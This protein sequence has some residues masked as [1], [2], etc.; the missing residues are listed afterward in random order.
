MWLN[1][2]EINHLV[3]DYNGIFNHVVIKNINQ[4]FL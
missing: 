3:C 1:M 4:F 2:I